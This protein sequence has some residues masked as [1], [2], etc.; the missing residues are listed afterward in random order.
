MLSEMMEVRDATR[1]W[2]HAAGRQRADAASEL[3]LRA[4]ELMQALAWWGVDTPEARA[5]KG[6]LGVYQADPET[7]YRSPDAPG[8]RAVTDAIVTAFDAFARSAHGRQAEAGDRDPVRAMPAEAGRWVSEAAFGVPANC[9]QM[10]L[11][12]C[13]RG[14][15]NPA[16]L[17]LAGRAVGTGPALTEDE[18]CAL[19]EKYA[20][21]AEYWLNGHC[22]PPGY[23]FGWKD[24]SFYFES[25]EWWAEHDG[26]DQL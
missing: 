14:W 21:E 24:L 4:E 16:A 1:A 26:P 19:C 23:L 7:W 8:S 3:A 15:V 18:S 25:A 12:A 20:I 10:V 11:L 5:L 13:A 22:A 17:A 9:G 6:A 2:Q